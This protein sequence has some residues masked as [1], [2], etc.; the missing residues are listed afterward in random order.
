VTAQR[1]RAL[2]SLASALAVV[3]VAKS[4]HASPSAKLV[5]VRASGAE[6][7]PA[8]PDLRRAV[9]TRLGYDPFFPSATKTVVA[10]IAHGAA[11]Y[12]ARIRILGDDG[13]VRGERELAPSGEDCR[14]L[15]AALGLAVSIALDDLDDVVLAPPTTRASAERPVSPSDLQAAPATTPPPPA[16]APDTPLAAPPASRAGTASRAELVV[17]AGPSV[18]VGSA[19]APAAGAG[20]AATLRGRFIGLR[21]DLRGDLP[22]SQTLAVNEPGANADGR[23]RVST[24]LWLA[25]LSGCLRPSPA[26]LCLGAGIGRVSSHTGGIARTADDSATIVVTTFRA[27]LEVPVSRRLYVSPLLEGHLGLA[28]PSV[29]IDSVSVHEMARFSATAGLHL[30]LH[31]F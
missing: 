15:V 30:G 9:A 21:L 26:V 3:G 18:S 17:S 10:E 5:Y 2:L 22:S 13:L 23:A 12:R 20:I 25:G 16:L 31:I 24:S 1:R 4:A 8:E 6:T 11:G 19:P 27:G 7:C 14:E 28:R 29:V